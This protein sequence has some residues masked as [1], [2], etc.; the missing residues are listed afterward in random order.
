MQS[1]LYSRNSERN[2]SNTEVCLKQNK[3]KTACPKELCLL[4]TE[5]NLSEKILHNAFWPFY[6]TSAIASDKWQ[7]FFINFILQRKA[8]NR[9]QY[10]ICLYLATYPLSWLALQQCKELCP[11]RWKSWISRVISFLGQERV[12]LLLTVKVV[13]QTSKISLLVT[14]GETAKAFQLKDLSLAVHGS[15]VSSYQQKLQSETEIV[16]SIG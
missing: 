6:I 11:S 4:N 5:G 13:S 1:I 8:V 15:F 10:P 3:T 2:S 9:R 12:L 16:Y 14:H 7:L